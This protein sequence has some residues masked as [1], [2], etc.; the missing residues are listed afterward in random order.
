MTAKR[1]AFNFT[2]K[3]HLEQFMEENVPDVA[4]Y[5]FDQTGQFLAAEPL[6]KGKEGTAKFALPLDVA[7]TTMRVV[8]GPRQFEER[9]ELPKWLARLFHGDEDRRKGPSLANLI[10]MGGYEKRVHLAEENILNMVIFPDVW[11]AWLLCSCVVRGRLVKRVPLPDGTTQ[12]LGVCHACVK[13]YEVD[14]IP[15]IIMRLPERDLFRLR[16]DLVRFIDKPFPWPP[17]PDPPPERIGKPVGPLRETK[18]ATAPT[19]CAAL[20]APSGARATEKAAAPLATDRLRAELEPVFQAA[21]V[22][23]LRHVLLDRPEILKVYLCALGWPKYWLHSDLIKC[24][25]TDE[26]GR[27]ETTIWYRCGG[28]KPDLY[29]KA[30]QCIGGTLHTLYD[31]GVAC[32]THWNY[33]CGTEV[34]L[35]TDDPAAITCVPP[36]PVLPPTGVTTWVMP[37]GVGGI[38]QNRIKTSGLTDFTDE[39]GTWIDAPFG[40]QLGFRMGYSSGIPYDIVN[41]PAYYRCLY[42]QL[43]SDGD[44]TQWREFAAPVASTVV[45]HYVDY[46]LAHPELPPTF[47]AYP[48]GPQEKN[49]KHLYEFKPHQP[50]PLAGHIREWPVDNWFADI[51]AAILQSGIL[52]GGIGAAAGKYKIKLEVYDKNGTLIIPGGGTFNFIVPTGFDA[53]GVTILTRAANAGEI[54]G[55]GFVFTLHMD[56]NKCV[57]EIY[58][59]RVNSV[60]AGPCG[61]IAYGHGDDVHLSFKAYHPNGFGRFKFTVVRGSSGY[62]AAACAPANPDVAWANAPRVTDTPVNG[63]SRDAA[64]IYTKDVDETIMRDGCPKAA[65]GENLYVAATGTNGWTRL[66]GLDASG[67][68]MA[69]A[70]EPKTP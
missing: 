66:S 4:V 58:E 67:L 65:F 17:L 34:V 31:P 40:G 30:L 41:K 46:D 22:S 42:N 60:P 9:E 3:V 15:K 49:S 19:P 18:P 5:L 35:E 64:G 1:A 33:P 63:Y 56:N 29:F 45:R 39:N 50:P 53:D 6:A 59:A 70:L 32:H 7:R 61:F 47:P 23:Q 51:Y 2:V 8:L 68:P 54:E 57:A 69:F 14:K 24:V 11:R 44:E 43:D 37:W 26:Q 36:D 25:C 55:G 52:P 28:D 48:L 62:V 12:E 16:D 27:F 21:S 10:R 13:I 20:A 38:L